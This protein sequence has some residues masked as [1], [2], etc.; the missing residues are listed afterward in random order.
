MLNA[1]SVHCQQII[2]LIDLNAPSTHAPESGTGR[3][4]L[5]KKNNANIFRP[6]VLFCVLD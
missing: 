4:V 2:E 6:H 5:Y 3:N 1:S